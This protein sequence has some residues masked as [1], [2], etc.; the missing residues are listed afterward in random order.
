MNMQVSEVRP[1]WVNTKL[2]RN[3]VSDETSWIQLGFSEDREFYNFK[4]LEPKVSAWS[5]YPTP[6]EPGRLYKFTG[7]EVNFSPDL[8]TVYR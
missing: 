3:I 5:F 6:E 2:E 1:N 7:F 4:V 8:K